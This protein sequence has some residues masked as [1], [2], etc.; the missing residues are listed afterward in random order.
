MNKRKAVIGYATYWV[1][2]RMAERIIR[3]QVK[4]RV[5]GL[6]GSGERSTVRRRLPLVG[7]VAALAAAAAVVLTRH[8]G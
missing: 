5:A 1:G 7:A 8:R 2:R 4:R 6:L 3:R